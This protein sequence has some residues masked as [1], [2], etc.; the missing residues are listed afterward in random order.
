MP[1]P[2]WPCGVA[3]PAIGRAVGDE[4]A[5]VGAAQRDRRE[6]QAAGDGRGVALG[7]VGLLAVAQLT[8]RVVAPTPRRTVGGGEPARVGVAAERQHLERERGRR[9]A[10]CSLVLPRRVAELPAG[11]RTPAIGRTRGGEATH[12]VLPGHDRL[13]ARRCP[14]PDRVRSCWPSHHRRRWRRCRAGPTELSPQHQVAPALVK[15]QVK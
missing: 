5:S 7:G 8:E 3:A 13:R 4:T 15:P 14:A 9:S 2:S 12:V 10:R 11:V 1:S 6:L